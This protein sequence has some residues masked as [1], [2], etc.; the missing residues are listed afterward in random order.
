VL[1]LPVI[2][3]DSI[4]TALSYEASAKLRVVFMKP[5]LEGSTPTSYWNENV[6]IPVYEND[7]KQW[8]DFRINSIALVGFY[9]ICR[10]FRDQHSNL[11]LCLF[12]LSC[13]IK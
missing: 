5:M 4:N 12:E 11:N 2:T 8:L 9:N 1:P 3:R 6:L 13:F 10:K 7:F